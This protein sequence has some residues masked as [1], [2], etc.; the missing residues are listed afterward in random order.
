[1]IA[2]ALMHQS[3]ERSLKTRKI[4]KNKKDLFINRVAAV[5]NLGKIR[6]LELKEAAP[7]RP[8]ASP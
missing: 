5:D 4:Y 6:H 2:A 8:R 7:P 3:L 1:M